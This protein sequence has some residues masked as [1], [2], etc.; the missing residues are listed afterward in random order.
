LLLEAIQ[1]ESQE[2]RFDLDGSGKINASDLDM[3]VE[4]V[5]GTW[6]GDADLDGEFNTGD[7]VQVLGAGKYERQEYAGWAEG[8]WNGDG[9]FGTG[10]LVMALEDGGYEKG[11]REDV[12]A[13]PEPT[14][15][16]LFVMGLLTGP[17]RRP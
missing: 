3:M 11:P 12:A 9:V 15:W 14:G 7:L 8:D 13:V 17:R 6:Y 16:W 2:L 1:I 4:D 10:D 5:F